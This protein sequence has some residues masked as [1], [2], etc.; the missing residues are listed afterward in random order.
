MSFMYL[1]WCYCEVFGVGSLILVNVCGLTRKKESPVW[2]VGGT[3]DTTVV[4][5]P[6]LSIAPPPMMFVLL[7]S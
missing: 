1:S 5:I 3:M 4:L 6:V 2:P 7:H